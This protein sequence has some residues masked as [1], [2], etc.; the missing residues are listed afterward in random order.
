MELPQTSKQSHLTKSDTKIQGLPN[1]ML[2]R[3]D[4]YSLGRKFVVKFGG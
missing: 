2:R 1:D 4:S 3:L